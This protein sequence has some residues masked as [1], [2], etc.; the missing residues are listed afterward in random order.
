MTYTAQL[1]LPTDLSGFGFSGGPAYQTK[2]V[3]TPNGAEYR[4]A[5]RGYSLGRY[6]VRFQAMLDSARAGSRF[7]SFEEMFAFFNNAQGM[8]LSFRAKDPMDW[9]TTS[10]TGKFIATS[11]ATEWQMV[12][13]YTTGSATRDRIITKPYAT[14]TATSG[15]VDYDSG[16]VTNATMP[17]SWSGSYYLNVRFDT[18][19]MLPRWFDNHGPSPVLGWDDI[20]LVEVSE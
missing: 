10:T 7:V 12:K 18:D 19:E 6:V 4:D 11:V 1:I 2:I 20:P 3:R 8:G 5:L 17:T 15:T 16:I 13:R 14:A 9:T